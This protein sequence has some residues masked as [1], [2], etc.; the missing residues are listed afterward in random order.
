MGNNL[1]YELHS[2]YLPKEFRLIE[3]IEWRVQYPPTLFFHT[4]LKV[5]TKLKFN[6]LDKV[7]TN[8][9][10]PTFETRTNIKR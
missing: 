4:P 7:W 9:E 5:S 2:K 8:M 10:I 1:N 6:I 3:V